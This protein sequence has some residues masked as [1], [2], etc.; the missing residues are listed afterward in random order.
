[1]W[2]RIQTDWIG[3]ILAVRRTHGV[4]VTAFQKKPSSGHP[5]IYAFGSD[6]HPLRSQEYRS[7]TSS[8]QQKNTT[9]GNIY[10][11]W[12]GQTPEDTGIKN[13]GSRVLM[14]GYWQT[15]NIVEKVTHNICHKILRLLTDNQRCGY[16]NKFLFRIRISVNSELRIREEN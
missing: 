3:Q 2:N 11:E 12:K 13:P 15:S 5:E 14:L 6:A 1:M 7:E 16:V 4:T 8:S 9:L 10:R